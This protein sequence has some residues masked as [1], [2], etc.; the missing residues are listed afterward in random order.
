MS[1][2]K[3]KKIQ[4]TRKTKKKSSLTKPI[5]HKRKH[6]NAYKVVDVTNNEIVEKAYG[7]GVQIIVESLSAFKECVKRL[8]DI[9]A[10]VFRTTHQYALGQHSTVYFFP[11]QG[12]LIMYAEP[13][14]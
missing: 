10:I 13:Q 6:A 3:T 12:Y 7:N 1:K 8:Q 14:K 5:A 4:R 2:T 9:D 11:Y